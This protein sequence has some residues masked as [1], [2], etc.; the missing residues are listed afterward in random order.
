MRRTVPC[1]YL[2]RRSPMVIVYESKTGFTEK[3]ARMLA[4]KTGLKAMRVEDFSRSEEAARGEEVIFLGWIMA[5]KIQGLNK[6]RNHSLKAVCATGTARSPEPDEK[7]FVARNKI[8]QL[9]FFYLRGGCLPIK[10]YKGIDRFLLT[11]FLGMLKLMAR[12]NEELQESIEH[13]E[14]GFDGVK[15]ENLEP[16][17]QWLGVQGHG[18]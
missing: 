8:S 18:R 6:V 3:Y 13:L 15:E 16:V 2:E 11:I 4:D 5:G 12:K 10:E 17:L 7:T 14:K 1:F 9:P